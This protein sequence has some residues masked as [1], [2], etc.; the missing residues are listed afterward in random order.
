MAFKLCCSC[1]QNDITIRR[2]NTSTGATV[3]EYGPGQ[4]WTWHYGSDLITGWYVPKA[5]VL[6]RRVQAVGTSWTRSGLTANGAEA[7]HFVTIDADDGTVVS[8][9]EIL[10]LFATGTTKGRYTPQ[11]SMSLHGLSGGNIVAG[12]SRV[13]IIELVDFTS[14]TATKQYILHQ[15]G[16]TLGNVTLR[17][18]GNVDCVFSCTAS[19]A[20]IE[21]AIDALTEVTSVTV[22]G[23]PWPL[24]P[25]TIDVVWSSSSGDFKTFSTESTSGGIST[26]ISAI[27]YDRTTGEILSAVGAQFGFGTGVT[28]TKLI[29]S[30]TAS[31]PAPGTAPSTVT[32]PLRA[33]ADNK[34]LMGT[35]TRTTA[36]E[37][38]TVGT[39]WSRNWVVWLNSPSTWSLTCAL[40]NVEDNIVC[41][42]HGLTES[43]GGSGYTDFGRWGEKIDCG[44][45]TVTS[46]D[47]GID[48]AGEGNFL[49]WFGT[50]AVI[51][52]DSN[53]ASMV[54]QYPFLGW[55][56]VE[57]WNGDGTEGY[58]DSVGV[59][60]TDGANIAL[61]EINEDDFPIIDA[62]HPS[63]FARWSD[64]IGLLYGC[65]STR[66]LGTRTRGGATGIANSRIGRNYA[67]KQEFISQPINGSYYR[68]WW[69]YQLEDATRATAG[70]F[71]IQI[72]WTNS[73]VTYIYTDWLDWLTTTEADLKDALTSIV[74]HAGS[75]WVDGT[76]WPLVEVG[77]IFNGAGQST[78]VHTDDRTHYGI[79]ERGVAIVFT[80]DRNTAND[81]FIHSSKQFAFTSSAN[82]VFEFRNMTWHPYSDT[83]VC[84]YDRDNDAA[85]IWGRTWR[86]RSGAP[87]ASAGSWFKNGKIVHFDQ[88]SRAE[89]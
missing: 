50:P 88:E 40:S 22:S 20:T 51:L 56:A 87:S 43:S 63:L 77:N 64:G 32:G 27:Y 29:S 6:T 58:D 35:M 39:S 46:F 72:K 59:P 53:S 1:G 14:N 84:L 25:V 47:R 2:Y 52:E 61:Q 37:C 86:A 23:G 34:V 54:L 9:A 41:V 15:H 82:I 83:A 31:A 44:S 7:V 36:L 76:N 74:G 3:W 4:G 75:T 73:P 8:D 81:R 71:R 11:F 57:A 65:D 80:V 79:L 38:W 66:I 67:R 28:P 26:G 89:L 60:L 24:S 49:G 70:E 85:P 21:A 48:G 5:T 17:T 12:Q 45:G 16:Q 13:P 62:T 78:L 30:G 42:S 33:V 68:Y 69:H 55:D 18:V 10:G 19:N